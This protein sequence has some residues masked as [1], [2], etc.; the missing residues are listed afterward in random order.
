MVVTLMLAGGRVDRNIFDKFGNTALL[1]AAQRKSVPMV[2]LLLDDKRVDRNIVAKYGGTAIIFAVRSRNVEMVTMLLADER[3]NPNMADEQ[4][5]TAIAIAVEQ[6]DAPV[7]AL[8]LRN[9]RVTV[10]MDVQSAILDNMGYFYSW[11]TPQISMLL[12]HRMLPEGHSLSVFSLVT[13]L[14]FVQ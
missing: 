14:S 4:D 13:I 7:V 3:V 6:G 11:V 2:A 10:S 8:L 9:Q 12:L 5:E 1:W